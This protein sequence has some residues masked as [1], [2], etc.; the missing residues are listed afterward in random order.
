MPSLI[1]PDIDPTRFRVD[2]D[3]VVQKWTSAPLEDSS[4]THHRNSNPTI[5]PVKPNMKLKEAVMFNR[6]KYIWVINLFPPKY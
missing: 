6:G 3:M 2:C 4:Q 1:D 5:K